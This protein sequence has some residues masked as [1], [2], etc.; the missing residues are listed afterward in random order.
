MGTV[1]KFRRHARA[2]SRR[3]ANDARTSDV[4]PALEALGSPQIDDQDPE[5]IR[6]RCHH[7]LTL[8]ESTPIS[9]ASASRVGQRSST[10]R[11]E[12][13]SMPECLRQ[14]VLDCQA[15]LSVERTAG[16]GQTVLMAQTALD[17]QA[18]SEF[19]AK[20]IARTAL[21]RENAGKTQEEMAAA[22]GILQSKYHKYESRSILP[23]YLLPNFCL[24]CG[25]G[26]EW[27]YTA[28]IEIKPLQTK[29][30]RRRNAKI[31]KK[32]FA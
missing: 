8:R 27:M 11:N 25:I 4:T 3:E 10:A 20:I 15:T 21:A 18:A 24:I 30:K 1:V 14:T 26:V 5:G 9:E 28:P 2:P 23:H 32:K 29:K 16:L 13:I 31:I 12:E 7:L 6:S 22:L 19:K 17:K